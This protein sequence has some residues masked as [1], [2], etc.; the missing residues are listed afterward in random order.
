MAWPPDCP[1]AAEHR[2]PARDAVSPQALLKDHKAQEGFGPYEKVA[3]K[4]AQILTPPA[5]PLPEDQVKLMSDTRRGCLIH[6]S[7]NI[8]IP[9]SFAQPLLQLL[10]RRGSVVHKEGPP[11][12]L[13]P[14]MFFSRPLTCANLHLPAL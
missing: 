10:R 1:H 9:P 11:C 4:A 6:L 2:P 8:R 5:L 14:F 3:E 13:L 7:I 12:L